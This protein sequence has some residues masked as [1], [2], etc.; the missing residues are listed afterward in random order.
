MRERHTV[1]RAVAPAQ[2]VLDHPVALAVEAQRILLQG[3]EA[4][5]PH[6]ERLLLER[7]EALGLV[8][9]L[10]PRQVLA[11]DVEGAGVATVGQPH[12]ALAGDVV[13]DLADGPDR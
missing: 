8:I 7:A 5:L 2:S 13:A 11:L 6:A 4:V 12:A 10:R 9:A 1:P 3:R